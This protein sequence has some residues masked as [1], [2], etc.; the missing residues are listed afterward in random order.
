M[1]SHQD[2]KW[3]SP[4]GPKDCLEQ[5]FRGKNIMTA[6]HCP[7]WRETSAAWGQLSADPDFGQCSK[8]TGE[9][10]EAQRHS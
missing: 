10:T 1:S 2:N 9:K 7:P 4:Q 8:F 3:V 6:W 5:M